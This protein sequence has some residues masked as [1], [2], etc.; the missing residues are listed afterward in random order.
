MSEDDPPEIPPASDDGP[1][2]AVGVVELAEPR[3]ELPAPGRRRPRMRKLRLLVVLLPLTLLALISFVFGMVLAVASDLP[4]LENYTQYKTARNSILTDI[5]GKEIGVLTDRNNRVLVSS[6]EIP[7]VMK[8]AIVAVEDKRF[9]SNSGIDLRSIGRALI[10]DIFHQRRAQGA[11]T[12]TEQFVKNALQAQNH[13]TIFEKLRE[14][15]LAWHLTHKWSKDKILTEYLNAIYFGNGAYGIESAARTYFGHDPATI[16]GEQQCGLPPHPECASLL[17]PDQAALLAGLVSSPSAYDPVFHP[18]AALARRNLVLG[19]MYRQGYLSYDD[20]RYSLQQSLPPPGDIQPPAEHAADPSVAYFTTWVK[21]Q[22]IDQFGA[23][24]AFEGG[25]RIKTSLDYNLQQAAQNAVDSYVDSPGGPQAA[26]VALDNR[27]GEVR[28]MVGGSNYNTTPFNLAT[29]GQRQPG[30]AFKVFDLAQALRE[31]ISPDSVWASAPQTFVVR[32]HFGREVFHVRNFESTYVGERTLADAT[33]YSDNSVYAAVGIKAGTSRIAGLAQAMGIRTPVSD[34]LAMTIGGLTQGVSPLDMA[35]AY[36]TLAHLGQKVTGSLAAH[37]DAGPVGIDSVT[38]PN[39]HVVHDRVRLY[40]ILP[41]SV[42]QEEDSILTTVISN[43]TATKANIGVW[44]AGKTGT[45]DNYGDAWFVGFT[46]DLTV[47]V[48]V[49]YPTSVKSM[50][51][52]FNGGPVEGGTY[53]ALIW[54]NFMQAALQYEANRAAAAQASAPSTGSTQTAAP[55]P[56]TPSSSTPTGPTPAPKHSSTTPSQGG[57][58]TPAPT[59]SPP[60]AAP[61]PSASGPAP[62]VS[63]PSGSGAAAAPSG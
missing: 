10:A 31:G 58:S 57:S 11:S 44:A 17:T 9:Y 14:A 49:G 26:L 5:N 1:H 16:E 24:A 50:A 7:L 27:T 47:A 34:N 19:D 12:I 37:T 18:A 8:H 15:A 54:A 45:T 3:R 39:G 48:W 53:P 32:D 43:G 36:L 59:P 22:V 46:H 51:T 4:P 56:A 38:Y 52:D 62:S 63:N 13:R 55:A 42:A 23:E 28:A 21:Q 35:H 29:Q 30:S 40:R 60:T 20:Y 2:G 33:T 41:A 61:P 25:L 6:T